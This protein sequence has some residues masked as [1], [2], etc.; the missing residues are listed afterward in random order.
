MHLNVLSSHVQEE[1][2]INNNIIYKNKLNLSSTT[3]IL[4][5]FFIH[6]NTKVFK[7]YFLHTLTNNI[8]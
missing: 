6:F 3:L 5:I 8:I 4:Q 1:L 7:Y 2:F